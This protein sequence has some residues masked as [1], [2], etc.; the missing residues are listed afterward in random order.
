NRRD[1]HEAER[2]LYVT[3]TRA[4]HTLVLVDDRDLFQQKNGMARAAQASVLQLQPGSENAARFQKLPSEAMTSFQTLQIRKTY[5]E[6]RAEA[7]RVVRLRRLDPQELVN[8]SSRAH[9]F[10]KRNPSG[11]ILPPSRA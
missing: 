1:R 6:Q 10:I 9:V 3:L 4:K 11:L 8:A 2:L 5:Q 7:D